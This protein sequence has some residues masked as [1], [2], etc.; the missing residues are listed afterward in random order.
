MTAN[1]F[2]KLTLM[3][4]KQQERTILST[5]YFESSSRFSFAQSL[6]AGTAFSGGPP[7]VPQAQGPS[8]LASV[9]HEHDFVCRQAQ[10]YTTLFL[11]CSWL[12]GAAAGKVD[13]PSLEGMNANKSSNASTE[14]A[15]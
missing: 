11:F 15:I 4:I 8:I 2:T 5:G 10:T 6:S 9:M 14:E 12:F 1:E 3:P 13:E 7:C